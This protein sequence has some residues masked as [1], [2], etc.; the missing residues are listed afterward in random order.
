M[1][2]AWKNLWTGL[3]FLVL[4]LTQQKGQ[5]QTYYLGTDCGSG[6][7]NQIM[8]DRGAFWQKRIL[9]N[10]STAAGSRKWEFDD[11]NDYFHTWRAPVGPLINI[12]GYNQV[13]PPN[14]LTASAFH[15][16]SY[17]GNG[18]RLLATTAL[19][20]YTFNI[21]ENGYANSYMAVLETS[22]NPVTFSTVNDA[23]GPYGSRIATVTM[24]GAPSTG[25]YVYIRY[26]TD[27]YATST[28]LHVV[29]FTGNVGT[30][31]VPVP[32]STGT[33]QYYAYSSN[34]TQSE[35]EAAVTTMGQISHDMFTLELSA[36]FSNDFFNPVV[37]TSSGGATLMN[38]YSTLKQAFDAINLGT[39]HTGVITIA[40]IGNFTETAAA[41]LNASGSGSASYTSIGIQP[42]GLARTI[43][44]NLNTPLISLNGA[45]HVTID[46]QIG[47]IG[48]TPALTFDNSNTGSGA[49]T[50]HFNHDASDNNLKY[51][52]ISGK[53][54]SNSSGIIVIDATGGTSGN[55]NIQID[56]CN[57]N[58]NA[59]AR[60]CIYAT[61]S[62][63]LINNGI[64][65]SSNNLFDY[66]G[67]SSAG[68]NM[69]QYNE[70]WTINGNS[71]YQTTSH[72]G[73]AGT[74]YGIYIG[75]DGASSNTQIH[76]NYI[77]GSA[78]SCSGN[79]TI[80]VPATTYRF[81][82][83]YLNFSSTTGSKVYNNT[84]SQFIW[85]SLSPS[86]LVPGI[87]TGI[88]LKSGSA[89][90]GTDGSNTLGSATGINSI[91]VALNQ[92]GATGA[93]YGIATESS[94]IGTIKVEN[95]FIGSITATCGVANSGNSVLPVYI[96]NSTGT[97]IINNNRIGSIV[98]PNSINAAATNSGLADVDQ[99]VVGIYSFTSGN[100]TITNNI[101][102]NFNN[103]FIFPHNSYG[104]NKGIHVIASTGIVNVSD[105]R[106]NHF[107][108]PQPMT[109]S[110]MHSSIIGICM[111][112]GSASGVTLSGNNINN[113]SNT[114]SSSAV[115]VLGIY[116]LGPT[117]ISNNVNGNFIHS[118]SVSSTTTTSEM[119][120]ILAAAGN[121]TFSNNIINLGNSTSNGC[122]L[123]G[124]FED[125]AA[126]QNNYI[127]FNTVYLCG[128]VTA[129]ANSYALYSNN[130]NSTR[131]FR[132]NI[133]YNAR[134]RTAG[135]SKHYAAYFNYG[136]SANLTLDYN[137]Y[138]APG[139]GGVL[140]SFNGADVTSLPL[141]AGQDAHSV[142]INPGLSDPGGTFGIN[143]IPGTATK[144]ATNTGITTDFAGNLRN[145]T[146]S[147]GAWEVEI[148]V[149]T[150]VFA[151]GATSDRCQEAG[152]VTY[153]A[154]ANNTTG[155]T[156][157]LDAAS[158]AGGNSIN[159]GTG[160]VT[161]VATWSGTTVI[162]ASAAGC[163]APKTAAHTV[164]VSAK[165]VTSPI[166]H[167]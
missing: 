167:N 54:L 28:L 71:F 47:G 53:S 64:I 96:Q 140:G 16:D 112:A 67:A 12:A 10:S 83:M 106:V 157:S 135:T 101:I 131:D 139:T 123:Y 127:Y 137:N 128:S 134:T 66:R 43:T 162:T 19:K 32:S 88:Y 15:R 72:T 145:C 42:A 75:P 113:L 111:E 93:V 50:I 20:Y 100:I 6:Y 55:D 33:L 115:N 76:D 17:G 46:G 26:T 5:A 110:S 40:L 73:T 125:G 98:T 148:E 27:N 103:A 8:V 4:L 90:F 69:A 78:A 118:L 82:G 124:I 120:G 155:I 58:G 45:D 80:D 63:G 165:P 159:S 121:T 160:E 51:C 2:L 35:I 143:Y 34:K 108:T 92:G 79:W 3:A 44:G 154:T 7:L 22:Y 31:T 29:S 49:S 133:F 97:C 153:S 149:S 142:A 94:G 126:G 23:P 70:D 119:Y 37:V 65:I 84:I 117:G 105:N 87:W 91:I 18:G 24:S 99:R 95:N 150:P 36:G 41:V 116:Y 158:L 85:R 107:S 62:G 114:A 60:N 102:A 52:D 138:Y 13:I 74:T 130:A 136:S 14:A 38:T 161:Y 21:S 48:A 68:I 39:A 104:V 1:K 86:Y 61:G 9:E 56:H 109:G 132:N 122:I 156:Y 57:I 25:E 30:A 163:P 152:T 11:N 81:V 147:M 166:Y 151:L 141:I 59:S 77:G 164:T 89:D 129:D 144:G 146:F